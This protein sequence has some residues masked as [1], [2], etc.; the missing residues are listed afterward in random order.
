MTDVP[1]KRRDFLATACATGCLVAAGCSTGAATAGDRRDLEPAQVPV[2]E[3]P[4]GGG[5][6]LAEHQL[7]LTQPAAGVFVAFSSVCTH[8]GC[9]VSEVS[10]GTINCG[11]HG[12]RYSITDGSVV[13]RPARE[14]LAAYAVTRTGDTLT[15]G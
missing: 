13:R 4:I 14:P 8:Q 9:L 7:V 2:S 3:V 10:D 1:M 15:I 6:I 5:I 11:C 12:S